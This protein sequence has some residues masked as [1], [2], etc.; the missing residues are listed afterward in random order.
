MQTTDKKFDTLEV[1]I[2]PSRIISNLPTLPTSKLPLVHHHPYSIRFKPV[3]DH[4]LHRPPKAR[5][6]E[7]VANEENNLNFASVG[8]GTNIQYTLSE[9]VPSEV[10][11]EEHRD[12]LV[13]TEEVVSQ[14]LEERKSSK[15]KSLKCMVIYLDLAYLGLWEEDLA[16]KRIK[17]KFSEVTSRL[18][19]REDGGTASLRNISVATATSDFTWD[20]ALGLGSLRYANGFSLCSVLD[21]LAHEPKVEPV[22]MEN[23]LEVLVRNP[24]LPTRV[25]IASGRVLENTDTVNDIIGSITNAMNGDQ[26]VLVVSV[27]QETKSSKWAAG[28]FQVESSRPIHPEYTDKSK[29]K[30][31]TGVLKLFTA[32]LDSFRLQ[33]DQLSQNQFF[34]I[35]PSVKKKVKG[36]GG[37]E[38]LDSIVTLLTNSE[39]SGKG[40]EEN[41]ALPAVLLGLGWELKEA[42]SQVE[43]EHST[44][45]GTLQQ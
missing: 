18:M 30:R 38:L 34:Y 21:L 24:E 3:K 39:V 43:D 36:D 35:C 40:D 17:E 10:T 16:L 33:V 11:F 9:R 14:L 28:F 13:P 37:I 41:L 31:P 2:P 32:L 42:Y 25:V 44:K 26:S 20:P 12:M 8:A 45:S 6:L 22:I 7:L 1:P 23:L 27:F 15:A 5:F 19:N 29:I 4:R